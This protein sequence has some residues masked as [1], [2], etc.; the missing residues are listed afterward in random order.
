MSARG[1]V[2]FT[3]GAFLKELYVS[4]P[5][6]PVVRIENYFAEIVTT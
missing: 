3:K 6:K 2:S 5:L 4:Y 1:V